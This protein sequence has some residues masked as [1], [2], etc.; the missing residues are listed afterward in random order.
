M[1]YRNFRIDENRARVI[2]FQIG[3]GLQ[4]LHSFGVVHRDLKLENIMMTDKTS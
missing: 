4:Y 3:G 2:A 1:K